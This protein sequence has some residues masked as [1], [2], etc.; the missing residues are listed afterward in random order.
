MPTTLANE[1]IVRALSVG[2][3]A[4]AALSSQGAVLRVH[5]VFRST[6]NLEVEGADILVALAGPQGLRYPHAVVLGS[7]EDFLLWPHPVSSGGSLEGPCIRLC[8]RDNRRTVDLGRARRRPRRI[9][10]SVRIPGRAYNACVLRLSEFQADRGCDFRLCRPGDLTQASTAMGKVLCRSA[11][12]LGAAV[13]ADG[14]PAAAVR[15]ATVSLVGAGGG[16]TPSGDDFLCGFIAAAR[17]SGGQQAQAQRGSALLL[18]LGEAIQEVI[19]S[20]G[21]ISASLLR[22]A[23]QG[24][25]PAPVADLAEALS[26]EHEPEALRALGDLCGLGHSSG[27]DIATGFLYGLHV[28]DDAG[29]GRSLQTVG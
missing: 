20:T 26:A 14:A 28:L 2:A 11:L 24:H 27:A 23:L 19:R 16:L 25:W 8:H 12:A 13:S 5:S 22:C 29:R 21:E 15:L 9:L 3:A 10:P 1:I 17:C 4:S 7:D 18:T 6:L